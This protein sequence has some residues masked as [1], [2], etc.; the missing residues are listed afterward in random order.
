MLFAYSAK[1]DLILKNIGKS[2]TICVGETHVVTLFLL[3]LYA[4]PMGHSP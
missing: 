3:F 1:F 2:V 4:V